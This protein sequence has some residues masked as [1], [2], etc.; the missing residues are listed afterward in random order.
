MRKFRL[1]AA[2]AVLGITT[3]ACDWYALAPISVCAVD[4]RV[5]VDRVGVDGLTVTLDTGQSAATSGGGKFRFDRVEGTTVIMT[6][7]GLPTTAALDHETGKT[8]FTCSGSV[9][10]NIELSSP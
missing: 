5:T 1:L 2:L 7:S 3:G 10:L 6:V 8:V 9:T 4:G